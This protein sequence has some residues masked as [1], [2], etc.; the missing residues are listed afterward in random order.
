MTDDTAFSFWIFKGGLSMTTYAKFNEFLNVGY[1]LNGLS[2]FR[3]YSDL[4]EYLTMPLRTGNII[5]LHHLW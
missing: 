2:S 1:F 3:C 4:V 5:I